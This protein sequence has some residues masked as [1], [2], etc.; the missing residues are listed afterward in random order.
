MSDPPPDFA[1]LYETE[2]AYVVRTL[3]RLGVAGPDL[4]DAAHDVFAAAFRC[5]DARDE[6]KPAQRW[7][8]GIAYRI[9]ALHLEQCFP[10]TSAKHDGGAQGLG[11]W[12]PF[13]LQHGRRGQGH[14]DPDWMSRLPFL[15]H[16][17]ALSPELE[18]LLV[19]EKPMPP[20]PDGLRERVL[21]RLC[22]TLGWNAPGSRGASG[23]RKGGEWPLR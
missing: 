14:D 6:A 1:S 8:F 15:A 11:C 5:W 20:P 21:D 17:P 9:V 19:A 12:N 18:L 3:T 22:T 7:L 16:L 23:P 13:G 2:F 4:E 10:E